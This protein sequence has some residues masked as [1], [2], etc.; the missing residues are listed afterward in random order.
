MLRRYSGKAQRNSADQR[1][2]RARFWERKWERRSAFGCGQT[3]SNAVILT[4][5]I[6]ITSGNV[7]EQRSC[8]PEPSVRI[9]VLVGGGLRGPLRAWPSR[10]QRPVLL[11]GMAGETA[12]HKPTCRTRREGVLI[13]EAASTN[14]EE[15]FKTL[16]LGADLYDWRDDEEF[17]RGKD[18]TGLLRG[19]LV[20]WRHMA[21]R[22]DTGVLRGPSPRL[23]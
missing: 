10:A 18:G 12:P 4:G 5:S 3:R 20:A 17:R 2:C 21:G 13:E 11:R 1:T 15:A 8:Q 23:F 7:L 19:H 9:E 16:L 6:A 22:V 14:G